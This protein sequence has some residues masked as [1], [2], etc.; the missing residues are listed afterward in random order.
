MI[1][2]MVADIIVRNRDDGYRF[3]LPLLRTQDGGLLLPRKGERLIVNNYGY[4]V[5]E[6]E[7]RYDSET[8]VAVR[9]Y[10]T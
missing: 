10:V 8:L 4:T 6:V 1:G 5:T 7:W 2:E 9:V 3:N